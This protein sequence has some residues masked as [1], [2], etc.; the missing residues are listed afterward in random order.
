MTLIAIAQPRIR[1]ARSWSQALASP[2]GDTQDDLA[3]MNVSDSTNVRGDGS[4]SHFRRNLSS[5]IGTSGPLG[6][7]AFLSLAEIE[8]T[9]TFVTC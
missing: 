6:R 8:M 5:S 9:D 7:I 3:N 1:R 2:K 4:A